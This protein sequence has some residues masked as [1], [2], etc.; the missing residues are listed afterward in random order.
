MIRGTQDF[1]SGLVYI[2]FGSSAVILA[3]DYGMGSALKMGPAYFPTILG[4]LLILIGSISIARSFLKQ[5]P[6]IGRFT[7]KGLAFVIVSTVLFGLTVRG[8]GLIIALPLLVIISAFA[9]DD[10]RWRP[11]LLLAVGL[12]VFCVL[13]F[14]KGLGIPLPILGPWFGG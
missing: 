9:S 1:A 6:S 4:G 7:I 11:T 12:T 10:F 8:A 3:R 5:G 14:L 13:V 2:F